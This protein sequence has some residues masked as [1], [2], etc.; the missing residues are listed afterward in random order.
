MSVILE[1][2]NCC[3]EATAQGRAL[4]ESEKSAYI[5]S[6]SQKALVLEEITRFGMEYVKVVTENKVLMAVPKSSIVM[7]K[8]VKH[9]TQ[10]KLQS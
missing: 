6:H 3:N 5:M 8:E 7:E 1:I 9:Q 10:E 2:I 4:T